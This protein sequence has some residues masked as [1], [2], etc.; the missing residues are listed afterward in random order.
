MGSKPRSVRGDGDNGWM[1]T[2]ENPLEA[3]L[4]ELVER[5]GALDPAMAVEPAARI[6]E[7]LGLMLEA[8]EDR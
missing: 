2:T 3:E 5:L 7:I 8:G 4:E 6:A 1:D